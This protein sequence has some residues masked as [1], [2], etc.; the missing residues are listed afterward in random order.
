MG[1]ILHRPDDLRHAIHAVER[2]LDGFWNFLAEIG[3]VRGA[4]SRPHRAN[5]FWRTGAG[6]GCA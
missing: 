1:K 2:L 3:H 6:L 5:Q 4:G